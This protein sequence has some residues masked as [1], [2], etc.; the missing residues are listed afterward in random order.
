M[1]SLAR[2]LHHM[3]PKGY[4]NPVATAV[5]I[6]NYNG[7]TFFVTSHNR[8]DENVHA[9]DTQRL[10]V[11]KDVVT[12]KLSS[13]DGAKFLAPNSGLGKKGPERLREDLKKL[14][15]TYKGDDDAKGGAQL[16]T[17]MRSAFAGMQLYDG[18]VQNVH[19][20]ATVVSQRAYPD[21]GEA[22]LDGVAIGVSKLSC[23]DC[24]DHADAHAQTDQLRGTHAQR[25]PGWT[26]PDTGR[27]TSTRAFDPNVNQY[28]S[29][30]ESNGRS[31]GDENI[32]R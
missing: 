23:G 24:F 16:K 1:D 31:S 27:R 7:E 25:F 21:Q 32:A 15:G 5:D 9:E 8:T 10:Q 2:V 4:T 30:S 12:G 22:A 13:G 17:A 3:P 19:A 11:L 18:T 20:E 14:R 29:D 6:R 28:P 26:N